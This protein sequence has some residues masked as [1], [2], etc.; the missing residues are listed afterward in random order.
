MDKT[1]I[2]A[3][4]IRHLHFS[5]PKIP[6]ISKKYLGFGIVGIVLFIG[7]IWYISP[8]VQKFFAGLN[9]PIEASLIP[10]KE[11]VYV[12]EEFQ[13]SMRLTSRE[14]SALELYLSYDGAI[15]S[16][17]TEFGEE[18]GFSQVTK[19]YFLSPL[20][21][22]VVPSSGGS[23]KT[24]HLL[25]VSHQGQL[26]AVQF[27]LKFKAL[28]EGVSDFITES[29]TRV[30]GSSD[31]DTA[32]YFELPE[33]VMTKVT[34]I[35]TGT[36]PGTCA[37][38]GET[39]S[40]D[41]C[42]SGYGPVCSAV[43]ADQSCVCQALD[44]TPT[45]TPAP[46]NS[47]TPEEGTP[48]PTTGVPSNAATLKMLPIS[49]NVILP[50]EFDVSVIVNSGTE[51]I[52][53]TDTY[54]AYDKEFL[55][56][57]SVLKGEHFAVINHTP[58]EGKLYIAATVANQGEF[59]KGT[60]TVA[61]IT[62]LSKKIGTTKL[63]FICD[64]SKPGSSSVI[65]ND[66]SATNIIDCNNMSD[67]T[68]EILEGASSPANTQIPTQPVGGARGDVELKIKV[69][70]QGVT[71][72]PAEAYRT[73]NT[74][75]I[76]A[77][78]D[79]SYRE[80]KV[81]PFEADGDGLWSG[82]FSAKNVALGAKYAIYIKGPKHLM[83]KICEAT[84]TESVSGTYDCSAE[85]I[86][87]K[88]GTQDMDMSKIILLVGDIPVQNGIIDSVDAVYVRNNF[89][90]T[91]SSSVSRGD[92]NLDGIVHAQDMVLMLKALEFKYDE[93]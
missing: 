45:Y 39:V 27:N 48:T 62:F 10:E 5:M 64:P 30:A 93:K 50:K 59:T 40:S 51:E 34:V 72:Q 3:Q 24:L 81:I 33:N 87:L 58:F 25:L 2:Q 9:P 66:I 52:M 23:I 65:K 89:G 16:Y 17:A 71:T 69:R 28:K 35:G 55:E 49:S 6:H 46:D 67:H 11:E 8:F 70:F 37:C 68:I 15:F 53:G 85:K 76:L 84:P 13:V 32:T 79:K 41:T 42:S 44:P 1:P 63:T 21:E 47:I 75:V 54:I 74:R 92:L 20:I 88:A 19:D 56:V 61:T 80:E 18:S 91:T 60:G 43:D 83:K 31:D 4:S 86:D 29:E 78:G 22:E 14:A 90:S 38:S 82:T 36:D 26:D 12:D 7:L 73:L 77:A 57:K